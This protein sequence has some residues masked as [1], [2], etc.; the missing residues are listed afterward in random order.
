MSCRTHRAPRP[1]RAHA[2]RPASAPSQPPHRSPSPTVDRVSPRSCAARCSRAS[3]R[4]GTALREVALAEALGV[5]R[6]TVREALGCWWPRGWPTGC[7]TRAPRCAASTPSRSGDVCRARIVIETA[8]VRSWD[9]AGEPARDEVRR[10]LRGL[11]RP[12]RAATAPPPSSPPPT[13]TIHRALAGADRLGRLVAAAEALHAEVRLALAEVDR[14]RG[15]AAE[16]VHSHG[17]LLDPAGGRATS[18]TPPRS[19]PPTS[20]RRR[21]P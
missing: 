6:S 19:S 11:L 2:G 15:N 12:A 14:A 21:S 18:T 13:S 10:A 4:P 16:Q 3:S 5:S 20:P 17:H 1:L 9:E 7:P 8:G